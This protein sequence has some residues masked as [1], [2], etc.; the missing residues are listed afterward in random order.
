MKT[1][2]AVALLFVAQSAQALQISGLVPAGGDSAPFA[3]TGSLLMIE[4]PATSDE[5]V[6]Y[7]GERG[8]PPAVPLVTA[9]VEPFAIAV[10]GPR[11][12][13]PQH[14]TW[15]TWTP[16]HQDAAG[17]AVAI[18]GGRRP[19]HTPSVD[20]MSMAT[21]G[22]VLGLGLIG[23]SW[24]R[25]RSRPPAVGHKRIAVDG[26]DFLRTVP[27]PRIVRLDVQTAT[28]DYPP[29]RDVNTSSS[30]RNQGAAEPQEGINY[31][32]A[33]YRIY[34]LNTTGIVD[35]AESGMFA[36]DGDAMAHARVFGEGQ[37]IE[38]WQGSREVAVLR[39][40]GAGT[41][42]GTSDYRFHRLDETGSVRTTFR[43]RLQN[44]AEAML[45][46]TALSQ[47]DSIDVWS[48]LRRLGI[49]CSGPLGTAN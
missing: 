35:T 46:A 16:V 6:D 28:S 11:I 42:A 39:G 21:A 19:L 4:G 40:A 23:V 48:P 5:R 10:Y 43:Q 45:H 36:S 26:R 27:T 47:G 38:V 34:R 49:V 22:C 17:T 44:D 2:V 8:S 12:Q 29:M 18:V 24:I 25:R 14:A 7:T 15:R 31:H 41:T 9:P 20:P 3:A 13:E 33:E 30:P 37:T 1:V 32:A